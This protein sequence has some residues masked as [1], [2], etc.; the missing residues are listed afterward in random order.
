MKTNTIPPLT[1]EQQALARRIQERLQERLSEEIQA[2][3]EMLA[4]REY[5]KLLGQTE[6]D[7]RDIVHRMGALAIETALTERKKGD[8]PAAVTVAPTVRRRPSSSAGR[9][10]PM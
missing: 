7:V 3:T 1:E 4:S 8:T 2:L 5:G 9:V 6:Y 10:K